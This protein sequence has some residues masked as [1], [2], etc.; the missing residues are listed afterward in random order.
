MKP[1][2]IA[3]VY[4]SIVRWATDLIEELNATLEYPPLTY[5]DW[6]NRADEDKLPQTTLLG[7]DGFSFAENGGLWTIR[8][9]LVLSSYRDQNLHNEIELLSAVQA[10]TGEG[11]KVPLRE[12]I[13]GE[14]VSELKVVDWQLM[15]MS[16]TLLRNH[17]VIGVEVLRTGS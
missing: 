3:P 2:I 9:A 10:R 5:H 4:K 1:E 15:P 14:Q 11:A 17:R 13:A 6:E 16:Q 8:F 7:L 12:M